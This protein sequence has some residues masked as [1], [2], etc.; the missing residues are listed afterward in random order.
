V[1]TNNPKKLAGLQ[2]YG[3]EIAAQV[4]LVIAPNKHNS[5]YLETK[6]DKLGHLL[7]KPE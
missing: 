3:L 5:K 7:Q 1:L 2:G 4:P 6:R